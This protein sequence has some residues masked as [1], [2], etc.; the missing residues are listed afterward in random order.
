[1]TA[2]LMAL[3]FSLHQAKYSLNQCKRD[4]NCAAEWL[5]AHADEVPIGMDIDTNSSVG[6]IWHP[7]FRKNLILGLQAY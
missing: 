4:V 2:Q 1:M 7:F 6:W 3:G 5:L